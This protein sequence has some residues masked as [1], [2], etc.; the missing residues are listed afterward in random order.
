MKFE[1]KFNVDIPWI[2][3]YDNLDDKIISEVR[4]EFVHTLAQQLVSANYG[5]GRMYENIHSLVNDAIKVAVDKAV[6]DIENRI[7]R[8][9]K[10]ADI[11]RET[12]D[13]QKEIQSCVKR[14]IKSIDFA[15]L[16]EQAIAK[17][18]K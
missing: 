6:D 17:K 12:I 14:E 7:A 2:D 1:V 10:I 18:F 8:K 4:Y 11:E 3:E 9:R 5:S 13:L 15:A 16:M